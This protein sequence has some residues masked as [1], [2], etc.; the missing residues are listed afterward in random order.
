MS[1]GLEGEERLA[2][3]TLKRSGKVSGRRQWFDAI[4]EVGG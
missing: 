4:G 3:D 2:D 1:N